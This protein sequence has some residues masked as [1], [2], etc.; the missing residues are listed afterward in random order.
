MKSY[1]KEQQKILTLISDKVNQE[2]SINEITT[3]GNGIKKIYD[4][5]VINNRIKQAHEILEEFIKKYESIPD[6]YSIPLIKEL[7]KRDN[8]LWTQ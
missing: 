4:T 1:I 8:K 6:I 5:L 2:Q 3:I 7:I